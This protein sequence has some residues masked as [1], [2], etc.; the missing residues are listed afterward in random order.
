VGNV[1]NELEVNDA[2]KVA[3]FYVDLKAG[4]TSLQAFFNTASTKQKVN[5]EY[6][7]VERIGSADMQKLK[8]YHAS[9]PDEL[10]K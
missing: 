4:E 9:S 1:F 8:A 5:A 3:T 2:D 6:V 10:L 7:Y